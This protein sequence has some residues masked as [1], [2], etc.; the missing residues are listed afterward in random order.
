[1][2]HLKFPAKKIGL[3]G[4]AIIASLCVLKF[5]YFYN[6]LPN[7][8]Q[9]PLEY[10][11]QIY[12]KDNHALRFF[13][14]TKGYW[15]FPIDLKNIDK[16]YIEALIEYEDKR[17][18][19]HHGVDFLSLSRAVIQLISERH[20]ISGASTISMQTIRLLQPAQRSWTNK[21]VEMLQAW[22]MEAE[23]SK[24]DI[25]AL[26]LSLAPYGGNIQGIEAA[27]YFYFGKTAR[28]LTYSEIALL[29]ALPQS[30]EQRR[31]DR[32]NQ[33]ASAGRNQVLNRLRDAGVITDD[34]F[35]LAKKQTLPQHR[36]QTP[37]WAPHLSQRLKQ[38]AKAGN[39]F[40]V[41][42]NL[43]FPLQ[44]KLQ[45][46]ADSLQAQFPVGETLAAM[47]VD[48]RTRQVIAHIG[49]GNYWDS[50]QIDLTQAIRS[51]GSTLKPFIYGLGFE[52][53]LFHP[54]SQVMDQP[55]RMVDGYG[56]KNFNNQFYGQ[57]DIIQALQ[58]SLNI[59]AIK[60]LNKVGAQTLVNRF[61][62]LG[63]Q[64]YLPKNQAPGLPI[65]LGGAGSNLEDLLA[66]YLGLANQGKYQSLTFFDKQKT[67]PFK[68]LLSA[69]ASWY[70]DYILQGVPLPAGYD[71]DE[72]NKIRFKTGTSYGFRDVWSIGYNNDYSVGVWRGRPDGGFT[73]NTSGLNYAAPILFE[74]FNFLPSTNNEALT[75]PQGVSLPGFTNL[76]RHMRWI[77]NESMA[78]L[79]DK[80]KIRY[81]LDG[82]TIEL[83]EPDRKAL[84]LKAQSGT[85]PY[86]WLIN[87]QYQPSF[88][89]GSHQQ[90][91]VKYKGRVRITLID[92]Q[93]QQAYSEIDLK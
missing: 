13:T 65:A 33:Q 17:F 5:Y 46:L 30:P 12:S 27:S 42:S 36:Y 50:S 84:V 54:Q 20:I 69:Q 76:P 52:K 45:R 78:Y 86:H 92:S 89:D 1:M 68:K 21:M 85:P 37:F 48:N 47:V 6:S 18:Y 39:G 91:L 77:E 51:P 26:Y 29:I 10:S 35:R 41:R 80:P 9:K 53:K 58:A 34:D 55:L 64:L 24:Q 82:S 61:N 44:L 60:A 62:S 74:I 4:L 67:E 75:K 3:I 81:P 59:P 32:H 56:P 40:K 11:V 7:P 83:I 16:K 19:Q 79:M 66:L 43:V 8:W 63:I 15:R 25:L 93:G 73:Q 23:L 28:R 49:S 72:F 57:V 71:Q 70:L 88:G 22:R 2:A 90:W 38:W 31:P 87:G 14:T